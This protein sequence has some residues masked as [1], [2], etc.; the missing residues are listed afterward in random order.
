[1]ENQIKELTI[2]LTKC[3]EEVASLKEQNQQHE[4][5]ITAMKQTFQLFSN[6]IN[7]IIHALNQLEA[8]ESEHYQIALSRS[9]YLNNAIANLKYEFFAPNFNTTDFFYPHIE[10]SF[11]TIDKIIKERKS[12]ARFGDGEFGIM[13]NVNRQKFQKYNAHLSVRL[14]E[15]IHCEHPNL[16][17]GI[18]NNY[19]DLQQYTEQAARGIRMY[20]TDEVRRAHQMFL[21]STRT[22]YDAYMSRP[23]VLYKDNQTDAP[24][25]RF[26][27]LQQIWQDRDIIFIEGALSRLGVGNNLFDNAR[28]IKRILAPATD[29]FDKYNDILEAALQYASYDTLFLLAVGPTATVLAHDLCLNGYQ[30]VDIGHVDIEYEWFLQGNGN[31][32]PVKTKYNNEF[33]GGDIVDSIDDPTYTAQILCSFA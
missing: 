2:L 15:V 1:M 21:D 29:S 28:S 5:Q 30:A 27:H 32:C 33:V 9:E 13:M 25:K 7:E 26:E 19:G 8:T 3:W 12:I 24:Q 20:M 10:D 16:L 18:A 17:I 31:R 6:S 23:Y 11:I 22:Y 14:Q 4:L